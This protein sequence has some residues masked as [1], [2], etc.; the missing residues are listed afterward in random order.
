M[1]IT[2]D[3]LRNVDNRD[4]RLIRATAR[5]RRGAPR[6]R[7]HWVFSPPEPPSTRRRSSNRR[8][9]DNRNFPI[10]VGGF[11]QGL[12]EHRGGSAPV[13]YIAG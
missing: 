4:Y 12:L 1:K 10:F 11:F 7:G 5:A 9:R 6:N 3:Y 8:R 2:A 13:V